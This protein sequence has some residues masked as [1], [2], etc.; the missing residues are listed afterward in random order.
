MTDFKERDLKINARLKSDYDLLINMGYNVVG[1]FLQG[2]QN[3]NLDY[4]ESDID[5]K[6][7]IV[8]KFEDFL[9]NKKPTSTTHILPSNE[10]VDIK[11]IRLMFECFKKQNINFLEVLFTK[12][13]YLNPFYEK[14]Y[15]PVLNDAEK[16]AHYNN[17][18]AINCI[19]G[20][21]FEK[22]VALCHPY[23]TLL[24]R[25]QKYGYDR[26]QL[27]HIFRCEEFLYR[28]C[29]GET[30]RNCLIP[31][32]AEYLLKV[33]SDPLFISLDEAISKSDEVV[34]KVKIYKQNYMDTTP[35]KV[36]KSVE[37]LLNTTLFNIFKETFKKELFLQS[38]DGEN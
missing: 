31:T 18:A 38:K 36:D 2:S 23:P 32:N 22:K 26:K 1:V 14:L 30:Y 37:E 10:H 6:A 20:M 13:Y 4:D 34:E 5:T 9:L 15:I 29:E 12:Y 19:A 16:I 27:H 7:I 28:F 3:Y 24:D 11:D 35:L 21:I 25:I 17:Y 8:P 33:K